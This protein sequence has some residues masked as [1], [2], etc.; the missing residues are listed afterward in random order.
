MQLVKH[1]QF[2]TIYHEHF[3]Y[4]SLHTVSKIFTQMGLQV[5]D[6]A[7]I[8]THGG[9]LRVYGCHPGARSISN[10]V[11]ALLEQE[12]AAGLQDMSTYQGFQGEVDQ[13]KDQLLDFLMAQ[14][15]AGKIVVGYGAAAKGNTLLNYAG[16]K[17]DLLPFICDAAPS[18]QGKLMPGSHI[19]IFAPAQIQE[20]KPDYVL[21]LPW[22]LQ[23]EITEQLGYIRD[24]GGFFVTAIPSLKIW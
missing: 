15:N 22:N 10:E 16:V 19:P 2:D 24:W 8:P 13:I 6:V 11:T 9:S 20:Q 14:K 4:L 21:I 17:P 1:R 23:S 5:W 12:K 7:Q 18:K 3:S